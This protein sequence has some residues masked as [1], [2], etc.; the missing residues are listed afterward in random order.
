MEPPR[1]HVLLSA[2]GRQESALTTVCEVGVRPQMRKDTHTTGG[3]TQ[4]CLLSQG[5]RRSSGK[6]WE[7]DLL[8]GEHFRVDGTLIEPCA[9]QKSFRRKDKNSQPPGE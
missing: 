7:H 1:C 4:Q 8:V 5:R 6:C 2:A 3:T 9:S